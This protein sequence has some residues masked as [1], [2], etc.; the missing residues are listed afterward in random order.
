M[1]VRL[2]ISVSSPIYISTGKF[3]GILHNFTRLSSQSTNPLKIIPRT[4]SFQFHPFWNDETM[5][6]WTPPKSQ[7]GKASMDSEHHIVTSESRKKC[8]DGGFMKKGVDLGKRGSYQ[9]SSSWNEML[10]FLS[11]HLFGVWGAVAASVL[12]I[13]AYAYSIYPCSSS[14]KSRIE[15]IL[16]GVEKFRLFLVVKVHSILCVTQQPQ[17]WELPVRW[18]C[19]RCTREEKKQQKSLGRFLSACFRS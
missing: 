9:E 5:F 7:A 14:S 11:H 4:I 1:N 3:R 8:S 10:A 2:K 17:P 19:T 12:T 13:L 6:W 15:Q 18:M 16:A